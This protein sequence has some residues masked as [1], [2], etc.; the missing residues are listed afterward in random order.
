M[1][2][3]RFLPLLSFPLALLVSWLVVELAIVILMASLPPGLL[4]SKVNA[5]LNA[6]TNIETFFHM[7]F[8][9]VAASVVPEG[10]EFGTER[11]RFHTIA[12][13]WGA[14][15]SYVF[16]AVNY[17]WPWVPFTRG[18]AVSASWADLLVDVGVQAAVIA[19]GFIGIYMAGGRAGGAITS[20]IPPDEEI[21]P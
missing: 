1:K 2:T 15:S 20:P 17:Q 10:N 7:G 13:L 18:M 21:P 16:A 3:H 4:L 6:H 8:A 9:C 14:Y 11:R 5:R 12:G 19:L